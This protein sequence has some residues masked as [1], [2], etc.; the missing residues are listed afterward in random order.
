MNE[1]IARIY[2]VHKSFTQGNNNLKVLKGINLELKTGEIVAIL[3]G[4]G[5]GKSTLLQLLGLLDNFNKG[6]II[7]QAE[8]TS[9]LSEQQKDNIRL[10]TIG[11]VYQFHHLLPEFTVLENVMMPLLIAG[12]SNNI[13]STKA[14]ELLEK[15]K[16]SNRTN[17]R[18]SQLSGGE[19]Q[20]TAIARALI[21][22][23]KLLLADEP[24]GN[25]DIENAQIVFD[26]MIKIVKQN[27]TTALIATHDLDLAKKADKIIKLDQGIIAV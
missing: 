12:H 1:I 20:R 26:E 27:N 17:H 22:N 24:T 2:Q 13:A 5:S 10:K 23:P 21:H 16:I 8:Q 3:G 7:I 14:L 25:L 11:F 18:P 9:L 15:M 4:S 6:E 19:Q